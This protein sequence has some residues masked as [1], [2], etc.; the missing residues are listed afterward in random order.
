MELLTQ[1]YY[2]QE[3]NGSPRRIITMDRLRVKQHATPHQTTGHGPGAVELRHRLYP[4]VWPHHGRHVL[5]LA[6]GAAARQSRTTALRMVPGCQ[7][8][9]RKEA[10]R[11]G[12]HA[13]LCAAAGLDC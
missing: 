3:T 9:G 7:G 11:T 13:V 6:D 8:Q 5:G 10:H 1:P 2:R 4:L 12:P